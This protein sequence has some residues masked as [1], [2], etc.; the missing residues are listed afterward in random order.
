M[1]YTHTHTCT[2]IHSSSN[3]LHLLSGPVAEIIEDE[4]EEER[5]EEERL[6]ELASTLSLDFSDI[7][8]GEEG[9]KGK[10][11]ESTKDGGAQDRVEQQDG[12]EQKTQGE[13]QEHGE[14]QED[15][16]KEAAPVAGEPETATELAGQVGDSNGGGSKKNG[17]G[18]DEA[19]TLPEGGSG[20]GEKG[21]DEVGDKEPETEANKDGGEDKTEGMNA[22][23]DGEPVSEEDKE[24]EIEQKQG[25]EHVS[26]GEPDGSKGDGGHLEAQHDSVSGRVSVILEEPEEGA[27]EVT[28]L[29]VGEDGQPPGYFRD[30]QSRSMSISKS[31]RLSGESHTDAD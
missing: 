28:L 27:S 1:T 2:H 25:G 12:G 11:P 29:T 14:G 10:T 6:T 13:G 19:K 5:E 24:G 31:R 30:L 15:G 3:L 17:D 20:E 8:E 16:E 4:L 21:E 23:G 9:D 22:A 26:E 18:S 7:T